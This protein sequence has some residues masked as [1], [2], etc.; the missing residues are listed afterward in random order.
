MHHNIPTSTYGSTPM[1]SLPNTTNT[2]TISSC[3][4]KAIQSSSQENISAIG[5]SDD[6][7]AGLLDGE[8]W[9]PLAVRGYLSKWTNLLHGWQERYF[10]LSDGFLT[11]YRNSDDL[12]LGSRGSV[13]I[14]N[15]YIKIHEYDECRFEV[16]V[17]DVIWYLRGLSQEERYTW[18][19]A[20]ERH[21]IAES[22]YGSEKTIHHH[23]SLLSLNSTYSPSIHSASSF[24]RNHGI[25]EKLAEMETFK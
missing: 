2:H 4:T 12:N 6:D 9:A 1:T 3:M 21:R 24:K 8:L 25:K 5:I 13:R 10:V 18:M 14:K 15:A 17:G 19:S 7:D 11:Y 16:R 23:S 20:I 22:G